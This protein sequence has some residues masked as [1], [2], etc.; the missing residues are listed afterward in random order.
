[1]NEPLSDDMIRQIAILIDNLEREAADDL[2]DQFT[3]EQQQEVRNA[4]VELSEIP[5]EERDALSR[6]FL[7]ELTAE[8][9]CP[10]SVE[11]EE[12]LA[13]PNCVED[14]AVV[15][16]GGPLAELIAGIPTERLGE[17]LRDESPQTQALV[18]TAMP[19][20]RAA[21][22]IAYLPARQQSDVLIRIAEL[23]YV[24]PL[25]IDALVEE[26]QYRD[27]GGAG[28]ER[29][30]SRVDFV[31]SIVAASDMPN[32]HRLIEA[33][34]SSDE[35]LADRI[36]RVPPIDAT[37]SV[38]MDPH[39]LSVEFDRIVDLESEAL[40]QVFSNVDASTAALALV[41]ASEPCLT[42]IFD[43]LSDAL[44]L[45]LQ[46]EIKHI[47]PLRLSDI[48]K[49]QVEVVS[50]SRSLR[51]GQGAGVETPMGSKL[52]LMA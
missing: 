4:L 24:Q 44:C 47:G 48:Q 50:Y 42:D 41:G 38:Q 13:E 35:V 37:R 43:R 6:S 14:R 40:E 49:A 21:A 2:L 52:K 19:S 8:D 17:I 27:Q 36:R 28:D 23:R 3:A 1:M 9:E 32:Q 34:A 18:V 11:G 29:M 51:R 20:D 16:P 39:V 15:V 45:R 26:I 30:A 5:V 7:K 31:Q 12:E 25:V 22:F 46:D 33:L 10:A